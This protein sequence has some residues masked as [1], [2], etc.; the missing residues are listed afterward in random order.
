MHRIEL[1]KINK[2]EKEKIEVNSLRNK[3]GFRDL[4]GSTYVDIITDRVKLL[5]GFLAEPVR[6]DLIQYLIHF[7]TD[8]PKTLLSSD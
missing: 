8:S 1:L 7:T 5:V 6:S 2:K 4:K 3:R